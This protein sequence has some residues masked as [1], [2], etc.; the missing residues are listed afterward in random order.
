[1]EKNKEIKVGGF[2]STATRYLDARLAGNATYCPSVVNCNVDKLTHKRAFG[3]ND[4]DF[5][6]TLLKPH[7]KMRQRVFASISGKVKG[8]E[9]PEGAEA[10]TD[11]APDASASTQ[12]AK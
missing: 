10:A 5:D 6:R 9:G 1:M 8:I 2:L 12:S 11:A 4:L 3:V 7:P